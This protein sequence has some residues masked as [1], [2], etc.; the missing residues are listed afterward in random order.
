IVIKKKLNKSIG[1]SVY[2]KHYLKIIYSLFFKR[3]N[4][5]YVHYASHNALPLILMNKFKKID[6]Y[7]NVHGGDV[8]PQTHAQKKMQ[9]YTKKLL[10]I[11]SKVVV[12]SLYFKELITSVYGISDYK[13]EIYPSAG[14]KKELFY[15]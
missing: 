8:V 2:L 1:L 3:Y 11:S 7:T 15:P 5:V 13:V 6:I 9:K 12:P 4:K 14:I 10:Q